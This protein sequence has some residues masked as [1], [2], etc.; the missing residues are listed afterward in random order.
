MA[1]N[2]VPFGRFAVDESALAARPRRAIY[3][4]TP[5]RGLN[6]LLHAW[7][8]IRQTVRGAELHVFSSMKVYR[9]EENPKYQELYRQAT[10]TP[11][12]TYHGSVGQAALRDAMTQCRVLAYPCSFYETSCITAMEAM[13]AGCGVAATAIGALPE[14]AWQ[15]PIVPVSADWLQQWCVEVCRLLADDAYYVHVARQNRAVARHYDWENV[16]TRALFRFR[17]DWFAGKGRQTGNNCPAP[18]LTHK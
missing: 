8:L 11:G 14:T 10:T 13:A 7:P 17:T 15:N 1:T 16:A 3:S 2:G 5:F 12:V 6:L 9:D 4:S 18:A